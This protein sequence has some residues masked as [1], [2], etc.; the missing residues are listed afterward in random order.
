MPQDMQE[1]CIV[2]NVGQELVARLGQHNTK[3]FSHKSDTA[4]DGESYLHKL[5]KRRI[6]E[7]FDSS[8]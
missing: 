4:C 7:K 3:H 6:K 8:E 1:N 5:A 2:Y